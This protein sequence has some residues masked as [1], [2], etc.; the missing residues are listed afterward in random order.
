MYIS[1]CSCSIDVHF[2]FYMFCTCTFLC[3][4]VELKRRMGWVWVHIWCACEIEKKKCYLWLVAH[5]D[6]QVGYLITAI[7]GC[8]R[9]ECDC[10]HT[11]KRAIF[12]KVDFSCASHKLYIVSSWI[13][14]CNVKSY[15]TKPSTIC[16]YNEDF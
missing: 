11:Y 1:I 13:L 2:H 10:V 6:S 9:M 7:L 16:Y 4:R 14:K 3:N 12:F 8:L 15:V 5:N